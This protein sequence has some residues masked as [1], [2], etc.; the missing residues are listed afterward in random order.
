MNIRTKN[1]P[2]AFALLVLAVSPV[3]VEARAIGGV[4]C[5]GGFFVNAPDKRIFWIQDL[6]GKKTEVHDGSEK[7][8]VIA[9]CSHGVVSV[10]SDDSGRSRAF[11]SPDCN[12][13]SKAEGVTQQIYEGNYA[14]T[15]LDINNKGLKIELD[16]GEEVESQA[17]R[18]R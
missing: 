14:V 12:N 17:C 8:V 3:V 6:K 7:M 1:R 10:F 15:G 16:S 13:I 4:S 2:F 11:Y 9:E 5:D 18:R